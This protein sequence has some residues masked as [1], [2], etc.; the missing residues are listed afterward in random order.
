M[1]LFG[2]L[3]KTGEGHGTPYVLKK[4]LAPLP[5]DVEYDYVT[6]DLPHPNTMTMYAYCGDTQ[7]CEQRVFSVGGGAVWFEGEPRHVSETVY[8]LNSFNEIKC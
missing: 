4:T 3:S 1:V 5:C 7:L 2:S 6:G 8:E